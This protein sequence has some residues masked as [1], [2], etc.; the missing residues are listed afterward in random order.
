MEMLMPYH[1]SHVSSVARKLIS[2]KIKLPVSPT[3]L[4]GELQKI[5]SWL[6]PQSEWRCRL[7]KQRQDPA[8]MSLNNRAEKHRDL[9]NSGTN[10]KSKTVE[11]F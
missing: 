1:V 9:S 8:K 11:A 2:T 3:L 7:R 6:T 10:L 5:F 4:L